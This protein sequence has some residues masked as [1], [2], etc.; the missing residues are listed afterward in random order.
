MKRL[1]DVTL[2]IL[3]L[4]LATALLLLLF[5][6]ALVVILIPSIWLDL[7]NLMYKL[8]FRPFYE[9]RELRDDSLV[10]SIAEEYK[11]FFLRKMHMFAVTV[12]TTKYIWEF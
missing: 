5:V 9:L 3:R 7:G 8:A 1:L 2:K 4:L 10:L 12:F 11:D 6:A